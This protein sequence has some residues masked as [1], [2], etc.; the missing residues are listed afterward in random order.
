MP[1]SDRAKVLDELRQQG[2]SE[3]LVLWMASNLVPATRGTTAAARQPP[4]PGKNAA[5]QPLVW[6]FD[7]KGAADL[8]EDYKRLDRWDLLCAPPAHTTMNILRAERSDRWTEDMIRTLAECA[9]KADLKAQEVCFPR[10]SMSA[11]L[12]SLCIFR[13]AL[14]ALPVDTVRL[15]LTYSDDGA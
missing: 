12:R 10:G 2:F 7:V 13:Y 3:A 6:A 1:V 15:A 9:A 5:A 11:E 4:Q 8:Y 14:A